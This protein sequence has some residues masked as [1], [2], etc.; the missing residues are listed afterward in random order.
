MSPKGFK[1]FMEERFKKLKLTK[2]EVAKRANVSR[3]ELYKLLDADVSAKIST[4]IGMA[5]ALELHPIEVIRQFF[6]QIKLPP[7]R[8]KS[9]IP[10]DFSG[11]VADVTYPDNETVTAGSEF[12]KIW[13]IQNLGNVV[14]ENRRLV[15]MDEQM[16]LF[17]KEGTEF[18][19]MERID[20]LPLQQE[21]PIPTTPA[22]ET[23]DIAVTFRAPIYPCTTVSYWKMVDADGE[24]PGS[25]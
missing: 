9:K 20:L 18:K 25:A 16:M 7:S 24:C 22:G 14:W 15:C 13:R 2:T 8:L 19:E 12:K 3:T 1:E 4:V 10:G 6:Y 23:V 11:F 5:K 21:V 17:R